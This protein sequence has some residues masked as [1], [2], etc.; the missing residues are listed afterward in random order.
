VAGGMTHNTN[1]H[2]LNKNEQVKN[3]QT[4]ACVAH[5]WKHLVQKYNR[6]N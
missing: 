1:S 2:Y 3:S 6:P 4:T 5:H